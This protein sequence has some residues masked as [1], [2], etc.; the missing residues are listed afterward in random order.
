[1]ARIMPAPAQVMA[2]KDQFEKTRTR[3]DSPGGPGDPAFSLDR[4]T[5][6]VGQSLKPEDIN[7]VFGSVFPPKEEVA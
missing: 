7:R 5:G 4:M 1:M 6:Q 2:E 3:S